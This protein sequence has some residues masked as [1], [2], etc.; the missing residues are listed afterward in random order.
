MCA[1][2][3]QLC[4]PLFDPIDCSLPG[5]SVHGIL[6]ARILEQTVMPFSRGS[7]RPRDWTQVFHIAGR[8]FTM[9]AR[10]EAL[11]LGIFPSCWK[12]LQWLPILHSWKVKSHTDPMW[13]VPKS[14][15]WSLSLRST[16]CLSH[17]ETLISSNVLCFLLYSGPCPCTSLAQN[18]FCSPFPL[19]VTWQV[20]GLNSEFPPP[21]VFS[22]TPLLHPISHNAPLASV[23]AN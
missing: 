14:L 13:S 4:P 16:L 7:S 10:R 17:T 8:F 15:S 2:L 5:S 21:K 9:W 11:S 12:N 23:L 20:Y 22:H 18:I 6:Q 1:R 3:L 19:P